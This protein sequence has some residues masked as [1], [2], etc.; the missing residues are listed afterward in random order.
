MLDRGLTLVG[1][2]WHSRH[3]E[4]DLIMQDHD[5]LVFVE[6]RYRKSASF[7]GALESITPG[8]QARILLAAQGFLQQHPAWQ[9][10]ACRFDVIALQGGQAPYQLQ[11]LQHAFML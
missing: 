7:G 3:G 9:S 10:H 2:N 4:L 11:W 8:K 5:T 6:V 1:R